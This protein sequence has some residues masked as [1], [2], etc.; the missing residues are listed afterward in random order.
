MMAELEENESGDVGR[1]REWLARAVRAP[2]DAAWTADGLVLDAWQPLSPLSGRLDAVE[3][4]VPAERDAI[5]QID[6]DDLAVI[7]A[8]P[9][10]VVEPPPMVVAA[11]APEVVTEAP[12]PAAEPEEPPAPILVE[13]EPAEAPEIEPAPEAPTPDDSPVET[14]PVIVAKS[15]EVRPAAEPLV[16]LPPPPDDPGPANGRGLARSLTPQSPFS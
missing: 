11:P 6:G 5:H 7:A 2:R 15:V 9:R 10:P 13:L 14:K 16:V 8:A 4:R 12:P 1:V 3:W